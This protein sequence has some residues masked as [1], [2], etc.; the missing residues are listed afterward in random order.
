M[1]VS[2]LQIAELVVHENRT[3]GGTPKMAVIGRAFLIAVGRVTL[4]SMS[5][6]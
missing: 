1:Q 5:K 4:K 3:I 6:D 2:S